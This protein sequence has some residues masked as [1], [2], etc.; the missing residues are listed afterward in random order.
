MTAPVLVFG[1]GNP[2]RGD[3][4]LGPE[5]VR[6]L[7]ERM[8]PQIARGELEVLTD[9]QLQIEHALDLKDRLC[10]YFVDASTAGADF[11][12]R[13]VEPKRDASFT[14]HLLSPA[15]LLHTFEE[16]EQAAPPH[17]WV[18][19]IRGERFEL[20]EPLSEDAERHLEIALEA[21]RRTWA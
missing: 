19:A 3:D 1:Y 5:F 20:G 6:R 16:V 12:V 21:F 10:V 7:S 14:S 8:G 4:A 15:A 2:S 9:Y 13:A 11:E 18:I 17:A